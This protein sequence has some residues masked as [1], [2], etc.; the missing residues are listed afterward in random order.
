MHYQEGSDTVLC[1][2]CKM[3]EKRGLVL[4]R[5]KDDAFAKIGYSQK[6][7]ERFDKHENSASHH[8][9]VGLLATIPNSTW[10]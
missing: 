8:E 7:L 2:Y 10:M 9:D 1:Y 5:N 6:A 4:H 3:A